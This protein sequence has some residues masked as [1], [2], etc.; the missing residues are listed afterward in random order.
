[1]WLAAQHASAVA[2]ADVTLQELIREAIAIYGTGVALSAAT[3]IDRSRVSRIASGAG[4][5]DDSLDVDNLLRL[6][7]AVGRPASDVLRIGGK[8]DYADLI[9]ELYGEQSKRAVS[10]DEWAIVQ[11]LRKQTPAKRR[12]LLEL[13]GLHIHE[14]PPQRSPTAL[15]KR[16]AKRKAG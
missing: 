9:E 5:P 7:K 1:M 15:R 10:D 14:A 16:S 8:N 3:G 11:R 2:C 13:F 4:G 12:M 6:A